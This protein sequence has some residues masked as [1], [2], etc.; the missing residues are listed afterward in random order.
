VSKI[1][2]ANIVDLLIIKLYIF[3]METRFLF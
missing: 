1:T 3:S 2:G